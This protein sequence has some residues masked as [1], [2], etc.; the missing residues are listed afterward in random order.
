MFTGVN[1]RCLYLFFIISF[2]QVQ[3]LNLELK[4]QCKSIAQYA[5]YQSGLNTFS[6]DILKAEVLK[7]DHHCS[8]ERY[9]FIEDPYTK[10]ISKSFF[11]NYSEQEHKNLFKSIK[12]VPI[13]KSS[14]F[15]I[16][17]LNLKVKTGI[18][19]CDR[20]LIALDKI[21]IHH[22]T[23]PNTT[24]FISQDQHFKNDGFAVAGYH[25]LMRGNY[26]YEA[27]KSS[28]KYIKPEIG[29][30]RPVEMIGGHNTHTINDPNLSQVNKH[31]FIENHLFN[32]PY[33]YKNADNYLE[34]NDGKGH[35]ISS[36][37]YFSKGKK[38]NGQT[39]LTEN[40]RSL[41]IGVIGKYYASNT[42]LSKENINLLAKSICK[43]VETYPQIHIVD[44]HQDTQNTNCPGNIDLQLKT[45]EE[46]VRLECGSLDIKFPHTDRKNHQFSENKEDHFNYFHF[47]RT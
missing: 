39:T 20:D 29:S 22:S 24:S 7:Y 46:R 15:K 21:T 37:Q 10:F 16:L 9:S 38:T 43:L 8:S 4:E 28:S 35:P 3:A 12:S 36:Y 23:A 30:A 47:D 26:E 5:T 18:A 2:F 25:F 1:L 34:C 41:G 32:D 14:L 40:M 6:L 33:D 42:Y 45:I 19:T 11:G 44:V 13:L 17:N 31:D 27:K